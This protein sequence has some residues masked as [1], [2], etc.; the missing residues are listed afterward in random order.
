MRLNQLATTLV[1][2]LVAP[3]AVARAGQIT[4]F[5]ASGEFTDGETLGGTYTVDTTTGVA[6]SIDLT[7]MTLDLLRGAPISSNVSILEDS[8]TVS[9]FYVQ[10]TLNNVT[11][12]D[13]SP[14]LLS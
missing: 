6:T 13:F 3:T 5:Q 14:A 9:G 10:F 1:L 7:L 11:G 12:P 8:E 4:V 2:A